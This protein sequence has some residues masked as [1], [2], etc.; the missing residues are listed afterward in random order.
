MTPFPTRSLTAT[1][2]G[3]G[4]VASATTAI[5]QPSLYPS[6]LAATGTLVAGVQ[7]GS[8]A[9]RKNEQKT[10]EAQKVGKVFS[11]LY[12]NNLGL[13]SPDQLSYNAEITIDRADAFLGALGEQQGAQ[14]IPT[15]KGMIYSFPHP[16]NVIKMLTDNAQNYI[17]QHEKDRTQPLL[18][19]NN[20]LKMRITDLEAALRLQAQQAEKI[21]REGELQPYVPQEPPL[22]TN[23]K[24]NNDPWSKL[25]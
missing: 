12:E 24:Q 11:M 14:K 18:M 8:E 19:E 16:K 21:I 1:L 10:I 23:T 17:A 22:R 7:L 13:V 5:F 20:T 9:R 3:L 15:E 2:F 4:I 25:L 6:T